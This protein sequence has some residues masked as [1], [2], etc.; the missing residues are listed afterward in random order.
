MLKGLEI[1]PYGKF[2]FFEYIK[3]SYLLYHWELQNQNWEMAKNVCDD[4]L[5]K[6]GEVEPRK[7]STHAEWVTYK[8]RIINRLEG[9]SNAQEYL[10]KYV[11][12]EKKDNLVNEYLYE[13]RKKAN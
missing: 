1:E 8:A 9:N 3:I 7:N 13:L 2:R 6:F 11:D 10:L 5:E 12:H 4:I